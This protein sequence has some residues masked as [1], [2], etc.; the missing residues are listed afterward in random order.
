G[1]NRDTR[2]TGPS[3]T[4]QFVKA[5]TLPMRVV[6]CVRAYRKFEG[7]YNF[8]VLTATL[9]DPKANLQSRLDLMGVSYQNGMRATRAFLAALDRAGQR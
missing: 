4:E 5:R 6:S 8:T 1:S 2:L 9:D 7:L 3:C